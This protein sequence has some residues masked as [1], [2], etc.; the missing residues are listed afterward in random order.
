MDRA[1]GDGSNPEGAKRK[2]LETL[3]SKRRFA[4][5]AVAGKVGRPQ[6]KP[7]YP[8]SPVKFLILNAPRP[9]RR[10]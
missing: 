1:G 10:R 3:V 6:A 8:P 7:P 5:F 4:Y 2:V 9:A